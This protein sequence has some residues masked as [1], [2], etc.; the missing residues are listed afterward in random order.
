MID[1]IGI[2]VSD[3][4]RSKAFYV[5]ALSPLG[6]T[7]IMEVQQNENDSLAA[8]L[9]ARGKPDFWIGGEGALDKPLTVTETHP[10]TTVTQTVTHQPVT[11]TATVQTTTTP[12]ATPAVTTTSTTTVTTTT[13]TGNPAAAAAAG[14]AAASGTDEDSSD[15]EQWGWIAFG[16]LAVANVIFG[17]VW[18]LRRRRSG[19]P[20]APA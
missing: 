17:I 8:G 7:L 18:F 11:V 15:T 1:H 5:S 4:A 20:P 9:G 13:T 19:H 3:Y 6:Y 12:A 10:G 16:V 14:A 2:P